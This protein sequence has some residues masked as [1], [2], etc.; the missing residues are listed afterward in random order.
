MAISIQLNERPV[1][2]EES[3]SILDLLTQQKEHLQ[4]PQ[5]FDELNWIHNPRCPLVNLIEVD[6]VV[7]P[8]AVWSK[9]MV[10]EG[11][12][13]RTRSKAIEALQQER[14]V[15]LRDHLEC[16]F[17]R[18]LQEF[19]AAEAESRGL[20][21]MDKRA[22]WQFEPRISSPSIFHDPN[23]CVR[24][25]ACV[26]TCNTTQGVGAL[27]F[28]EKL[29]VLFDD[30]KCTRCGQCIL[31]CPVGFRKMP[32]FVGNLMGCEPCPFSRPLGAMREMDDTRKVWDALHDKD[33]Y[34][35]V[36]FAPAVRATL[37]EEFGMEPGTLVTGKLYAGLRRLGFHQVW[38]TNFSADLTIMEEGF[39]LIHRL[40]NGETLP[41]FTSCSPG[42]IRYCEIFYPDLIA[43]LSTAKSPQQ[44]LGAVAKTF[45]A[46]KL[47]VDPRKMFVVSIMPCTAKK[48]EAAREEMN[49]ACRY[50][51]EK[52]QV[53][54]KDQFQDIDAVLT[55]REAAKLLKMGRVDLAAMAEE[56]P[57]PLLGQYTGAAPIFGRTGGVMEAALRTA[58]EVIAKE[59]LKKL[60]FE[61][62]GTLEGVK[63]A[64]VPVNGIDVKVAVVHGLGNAKK[65]CESVREGGEFS[66]YHFIEFMACEG[67]CIGGGGQ[68]IPTNT[69]MRKARTGGVNNDDRQQPL[70]KSHLNPEVE[71]LYKDFLHEPLGHV[72]HVLLHTTY[73]DR[74]PKPEPA[75]PTPSPAAT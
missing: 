66:K 53:E 56:Q 69:I 43:N 24:C 15:H 46:E 63:S 44:M 52:G 41:Q 31:S 64:T 61:S 28:D 45:A 3:V 38:D 39:E 2:L 34:V 29:G 23:A 11:M 32:G 30:A 58:Y 33:K 37:G 22:Q 47:G 9:R 68:V 19:V 13:I 62:L 25:K 70:R 75:P 27:S 17:I 55:S 16:Q 51:Q 60:T 67:G 54:E 4:R 12:S 8:I 36:Q 48:I 59:P 40:N 6:E 26:D 74:S 57:D 49:S 73:V 71:Q 50:W 1:S 72:S 42:W 35:V 5:S 10:R 18:Q 7:V 20:I 65:V 21:E 14:M